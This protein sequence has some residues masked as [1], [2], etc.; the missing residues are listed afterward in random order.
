MFPRALEDPKSLDDLRLRY[1]IWITFEKPHVLTIYGQTPA[2]LQEALAAI[3]WFIHDMRLT[4]EQDIARFVVQERSASPDNRPV[5]V[6]VGRRPCVVGETTGITKLVDEQKVPDTLWEDLGADLSTKAESLMGLGKD[7][8]MRV[9]FGRLN[10]RRKEK[11][12]PDEF[13]HQQFRKLLEPYG[14]RGNASLGKR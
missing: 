4:N 10:V 6:L 14:R 9:N 13:T 11:G 1:K 12:N 3:H 8:H 7:L 2:K 5:R